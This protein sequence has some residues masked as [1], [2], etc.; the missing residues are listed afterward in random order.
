MVMGLLL[1]P[2]R[3]KAEVIAAVLETG[4]VAAELLCTLL[5]SVWKKKKET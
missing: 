3:F 4:V 5:P 2:L 1:M